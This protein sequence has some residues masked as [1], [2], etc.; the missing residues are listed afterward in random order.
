[1]RTKIIS[2][3]VIG[4]FAFSAWSLVA[5]QVST[6]TSTLL[7]FGF[8][9]VP[10]KRS[11][12]NVYASCKVNGQ[13]ANLAV[14]TGAQRTA[15]TPGKLGSV[16]QSAK[17]HE[18]HAYGVMGEMSG[19]LRTGDVSD[20]Q[21]G[22]YN[23]GSH[24]VELW[25]FSRQNSPAWDF[26]RRRAA[27]GIRMDGLLGIDFLHR[28]QAVIDCFLM[29]LF[30]KS[31][32]APSSSAALSAGLKAGGC[33]EIPIHVVSD[34]L[35]VSVQ[36]NGKAGY[37]ILDTGAPWTVFRERAIADL[38]LRRVSAGINAGIADVQTGVTRVHTVYFQ[39]ME[40]GGFSV[41]PQGV[42]VADLPTLKSGG[43]GGVFFGYLGQ[44]LLSYYVGIVDCHALKLYL[45]LDPAVEAE[46]K[47]RNG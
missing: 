21:V 24:P 7:E 31:P 14:D 39:T 16:A 17:K 22:S 27:A 12:N 46:R 8:T 40:V 4:A 37:L 44:D 13:A 34:G 42:A 43:P 2:F 29:N 23:G 19:T 10:L 26:S 45:R 36:I 30:L 1:M 32:S 11:Q 20:F 3:V 25:D 35:A 6:I 18:G 41:P 15:V 28:H 5:R 33:I 47:K 9:V 38:N